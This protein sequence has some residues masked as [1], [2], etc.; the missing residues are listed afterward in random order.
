MLSALD[1][2]LELVYIA[3]AAGGGALLVGQTLLA[4]VGV[5]D[6]D[7]TDGGDFAGHGDA[8]HDATH[9][10][11][12]GFQLFSV[13]AVFAFFCFFG[14]AGWAATSAGLSGWAS[15]GIALAAGLSVM[16]LVAWLMKMQGRL[17]SEGNLRSADAV[18]K[19][20]RVY[21]RVPANQQGFGK[22]TVVLQNRTVE[23][24]AFTKGA[25]IP[26]G[27]TVKVVTQT[28]PDTFEVVLLQ[29][30]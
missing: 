22:I 8:G 15:I 30:A 14:L 10:G 26:T 27:A 11:D 24:N 9:G 13:R 23:Y 18:G 19:S 16:V 29:E 21:L 7:V 2:S 1:W 3:C 12:G 20:A 6:A 25:E 5:G 28:T 4:L 17:Q